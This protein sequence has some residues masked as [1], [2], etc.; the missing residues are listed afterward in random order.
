MH[1]DVQKTYFIRRRSTTLTFEK[2][3]EELFFRQFFADEKLTIYI[4]R[5]YNWQTHPLL[6]GIPM[7]RWIVEYLVLQGHSH[8]AEEVVATEHIRV[9][10]RQP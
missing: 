2:F 1:T 6:K 5:L 4:A 10:D 9:P 8:L 3:Q 7:R